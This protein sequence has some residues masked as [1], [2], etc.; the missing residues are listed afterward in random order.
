MNIQYNLIR[1]KI[2]PA[3]N[4]RT[5]RIKLKSDR[6]DKSIIVEKKDDIHEQSIYILTEKG[7]NIVG[8]GWLK[9]ELIII[10]DTFKNLK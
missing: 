6:F 3:T 9:E 8:H 4:K 1:V 7:F 5:Y 10:S 2:L